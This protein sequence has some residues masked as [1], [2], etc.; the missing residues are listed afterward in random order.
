MEKS[1]GNRC[2]RCHRDSLNVYYEEESGL[3]L[4]AVCSV[5]GLRAYFSDDKLAVMTA[6]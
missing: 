1:S 3:R 6:V 4:G 2:P 5:C